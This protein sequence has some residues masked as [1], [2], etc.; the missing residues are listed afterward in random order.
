MTTTDALSSTIRRSIE[1]AQIATPTTFEVRSPIDGAAFATA[2]DCGPEQ[3]RAAADRAVEAFASWKQTTAYERSA[4]LRRWMTLILDHGPGLARLMAMEMGKP[5]TE[6]SGEVRYA[7]NFVEWYAEEA[8]RVYGE[9]IPSQF[10]NKRILVMRQ[11]AGVV[12]AITPW[13]FPCAMVT[14]K[15]APAL[16][17]GCTVILKPAE[18]S[19]LSA[20]VLADLWREAGGPEGTLQVLPALDPVPASQ[21][22]LDDAR[23]R[24]LTFTGSTAVGMHLYEQCAKTMKRAGLELGGHAPYLVFGDADLDA[25]VAQVGACK[26][27]NA[28]QTCVCTNRIYVHESIADEFTARLARVAKSL[29]VGDP[30]DAATEIGP[31]VNADGLEK[32]R[33]HVKDALEKGACVETGGRA[34]DG[35]FFEPTVLTGVKRGMRML[36][37]ETFGPVAPVMTFREDAEAVGL[38]NDTRFGLAAYLWTRDMSRALRVSEALEYGIVGLNDGVPS[39]AQAPFGGVKNSGI[40]REGGHWGIDEFLDV[41]LVSI[42]L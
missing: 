22:L 34:L 15:V 40:G 13:N 10:A 9:T 35:L 29:R 19:P 36:E 28:G 31:L 24:V 12:Y 37:E 6:G 33:E 14:R 38:A 39:T 27:R 11:P 26:F 42:A 18:Q 23:V 4:I 16:A 3:A 8:K 20:L 5:V 2:A 1:R 21:V 32:V 25:A 7:A 41:K 17:A 30:L